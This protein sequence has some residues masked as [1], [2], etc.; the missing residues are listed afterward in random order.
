MRPDRIVCSAEQARELDAQTQR[1]LG[2]GSLQLMEAAG[3]GA[4]ISI[5]QHHPIGTPVL[6]LAGPGNNG[7]DGL[8]V[9]RILSQIGSP[10]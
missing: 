7:G 1:L 3:L 10:V 2:I 5:R 4:V 8:V 9:A 6:V